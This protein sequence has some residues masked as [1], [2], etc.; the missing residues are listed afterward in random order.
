MKGKKSIIPSKKIGFFTYQKLP[1]LYY[2]D[3]HLIQ[4]FKDEGIEII[5][6]IWDEKIDYD[7]FDLLIFRSAWDYHHKTKRFT[8]FLEELQAINTPVCNPPKIILENYDKYYLQALI[9]ADFNVI[10]TLFFENVKSVDL[11]Y[12]LSE[13]KW[14]RAVIK[15]VISM[16]A[17]HT[18]TFTNQNAAELQAKLRSYYGDTRVMIQPFAQEIVNEGEWSLV[19]YDKNYCFSA[20][21]MP[22]KGDFRVQSDF[23]GH[24]TF[25]DPP[26]NIIKEARS[27]LDYYGNDILYARMD[28]IIYNDHFQLME[29][30]LID[31]ELYFRAGEK[32]RQTFLGAIKKRLE[33]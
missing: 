20:L 27:I 11:S 29:A 14:A 31:P 21:K 9:Q 3:Q 24:I 25:T 2:D 30:E 33:Y 16:S 19:F 13:K 10:P 4:P 15:P 18:Y 28:G 32:G 6:L 5:P 22:K 7:A 17:Y 23:G 8:S 12:I 26:S 1:N